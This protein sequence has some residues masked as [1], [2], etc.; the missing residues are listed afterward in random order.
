M[1]STY[2]EKKKCRVGTM[3]EKQFYS[4]SSQLNGFSIWKRRLCQIATATASRSSSWF[5]S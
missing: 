3:D 4:E 5:A 2:D 1:P